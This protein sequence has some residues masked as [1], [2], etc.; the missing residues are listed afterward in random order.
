M[1]TPRTTHAGVCSLLSVII[2]LFTSCGNSDAVEQAL[3][4][5][6]ANRQ[7]LE[8]VLDHYRY[9]DRKKFRAASF[10]IANMPYHKSK[11]HITLPD[12][13]HRYFERLDSAYHDM[14]GGVPIDSIGQLMPREYNTFRRQLGEDFQ[15]LDMPVHEDNSVGDLH[16]ITADFLISHIDQ[17]FEAWKGDPLLTNMAYD[18]FKEFVLPYRTTD[19]EL[20]LRRADLRKQ[21]MPI[22]EKE[23]HILPKS[24]LPKYLLFDLYR[25]HDGHPQACR[26]AEEI[27]RHPVKVPSAQVQGIREEAENYLK[28]TNTN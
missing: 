8:S 19:E 3:N 5:A 14:F 6:E 9:T 15:Q 13:Y 1:L 22:L 2:V 7:E 17:A 26:W 11:Q 18:D 27:T 24:F 21:W 12:D 25:Q 23:V 16:R 4:Q 10:L 20:I 28:T